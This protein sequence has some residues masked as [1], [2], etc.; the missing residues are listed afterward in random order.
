MDHYLLSTDVVSIGRSEGNSIVL[1]WDTVSSRHCE[2]RRKGDDYEIVDLDSTNGTRINGKDLGDNRRTLR[3]SDSIVIGL[4]IKARLVLLREIQ[5][6]TRDST[7]S[8]GAIT[9][10]LVDPNLPPM[11]SINP[12]AAAVA[13]AS[14]GLR[15]G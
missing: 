14:R 7:G 8:F 1:D 6:P 4:K 5:R 9:Q 11:P 3:E 12:V 13:K 15:G 10:R 2:I